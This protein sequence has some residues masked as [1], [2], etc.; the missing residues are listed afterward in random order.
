MEWVVTKEA[1]IVAMYERKESPYH[2]EMVLV[3][4]GS[5]QMGNT[6]EEGKGENDESPVTVSISMDFWMG[7][8]EVT[9]EQF[10]AYCSDVGYEYAD[11]VDGRGRGKQPVVNVSW[12]QA[13]AY[14][15]W[16]SRKENIPIAYGEDGHFLDGNGNPTSDITQ[17][18]GY[19]LPTEAEWEYA[20][21]GGQYQR[22]WLYVGSDDPEE[23]AWYFQNCRTTRRPSPVGAK[24]PNS[25]G[26]YDMSGNVYEWCQDRYSQELPGGSNPLVFVG[27]DGALVIRGGTFRKY[28]K[29]LRVSAR[30]KIVDGTYSDVGFRI[31]RTATAGE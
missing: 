9:Y 19:R 5:F 21:R 2:G 8:T 25:L 31:A 1:T 13:T 29:D 10:D 11:E 6:W 7:K 17:V 15:N 3:K 23:V 18:R 22:D 14:C 27:E 16:L 20:A 28:E 26:L 4:A 12:C 24:K 30:E